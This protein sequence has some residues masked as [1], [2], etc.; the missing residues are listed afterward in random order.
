MDA[1]AVYFRKISLFLSVI[2]LCLVPISA[3]SDTHLW[4]T[5]P[6]L[7]EAACDITVKTTVPEQLPHEG[8]AVNMSNKQMRILLFGPPEQLTL[9]L[10]KTDVWDRRFAYDPV[11]TLDDI[12]KGAFDERNKE[13][14]S[15]SADYE[16]QRGEL[17]YLS[18]NGG[19]AV[20]Y[21][22]Y[23]HNFPMSKAVG[24][25]IISAP[26]FEGAGQPEAVVRCI[27]GV[28]GVH[29][30]KG[31]AEADITYLPMMTENIIAVGFEGSNLQSPPF[32]RLY[33][34]RDTD[35]WKWDAPW[36]RPLDPPVS[37]V[38]G[39]FFW[40]SQKLPG[41]KTFPDGFEYIMMGLII[42][43]S[44]GIET[45][46]RTKNLGT[47]MY[48][49][50]EDPDAIMN[51]ETE[52]SVQQ[53]GWYLLQ[54]FDRIRDA[55]G[56][57]ATAT[58][59][60]G[61]TVRFTA[62][63][64]V[65]TTND[66]PDLIE[67][68]KKRLLEAEKKGMKGLVAENAVWYRNLYDLRENGR[69]FDGTSGW[70]AKQ[71][72][73]IYKSWV[74]AHFPN[75]KP[76]PTRFEADP[77][78]G[79]IGDTGPW[80]SLPCYNELFYTHLNVINC[81]DR[82][83][84]YPLLVNHWLETC[85]IN[86]RQTFNLP[87][88]FLAYGYLPPIKAD[89][90]YPHTIN[91]WEFC[92]EI[93]AQV[94]KIGWDNFDY[95]GDERYLAQT[96]YPALRDLAIFYAAYAEKHDDGYYH[97]IPTM[98]AEHWGWTYR[99]EKNRDSASALSMF[100]W[101]FSRAAE[102]SEILGVDADLRATW[103]M[104]ADHMA[105]YPTW[106]SDEGT[107][108]TDMADV[109][110]IGVGYNWFAG[111]YPTI[112]ADE[113]NLDSPPEEQEI[114]LRSARLAKGWNNNLAFHLLGRELDPSQTYNGY[115]KP[116][117]VKTHEAFMGI[118]PGEP[119]RL[120]NSRSGVIHLFPC[121]PENASVGFKRFQARGGFLVT[122]E[123]IEGTTTT[124]LIESR[125]MVNCRLMNPWG[126]SSITLIRNGKQSEK[127]SGKL[128]EFATKPGETIEVVRAGK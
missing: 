56:S 18:P 19:R 14:P 93:P 34:H 97:V 55:K 79:I 62:L 40:I 66:G 25:V 96:V 49:P 86:A 61:G 29:L 39:R 76:D 101:T 65:V 114:M 98:S 85:R 128:L 27:D 100:E 106:E 84:Y 52:S 124:V 13:K 57:A 119:E 109:N 74:E 58:I 1:A 10:R 15:D 81:Q 28:T 107:I 16:A 43:G 37:G 116:V 118:L 35:P 63:V 110:P 88:M 117:P 33:R 42:E 3:Q 36:N 51:P 72:P 108:Y 48:S 5:E 95:G 91:T 99:F 127:L 54:Q 105:P 17:G 45:V 111:V 38:D 90:I 112:L 71:I 104:M 80:H 30:K 125:R 92:M 87:G 122:A 75:C 46:D 21:G 89:D 67:C 47:K 50:Y 73:G 70:A 24:Q 2:L 6:P 59:K 123:H 53:G 113:I 12:R 60:S 4:D 11:V 82:L 103:R 20:V 32:F 83:E 23:V 22:Y 126:E 120:L 8:G 78:Y 64:T 121:V 115:S 77:K 26:D 7:R 41:E 44:P 9:D 31:I 68:A 94:M 102:A 69:I